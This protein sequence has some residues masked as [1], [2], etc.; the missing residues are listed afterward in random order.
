[1]ESLGMYFGNDA[2][3]MSRRLDHDSGHVLIQ[4]CRNNGELV[5]GVAGA[6]GG[7]GAAGVVGGGGRCEAMGGWPEIGQQPLTKNK[8]L[9]D[10]ENC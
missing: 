6:R 2:Q 5:S 1:M 10:G 3:Q 4:Q 9:S 7:P 8:P